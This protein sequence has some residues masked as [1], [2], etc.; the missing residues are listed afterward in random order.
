MEVDRAGVRFAAVPSPPKGA[1]LV[2]V[3]KAA[4]PNPPGAVAFSTTRLLRAAVEVATHLPE[5]VRTRAAA[6]EVR[7]YDDIRLELSGG[8]TVVWGSAEQLT[9]KGKV[10][11]ALLKAVPHAHRY[12]VSS[13]STPATGS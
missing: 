9:Q 5:P 12:D 3:V 13:P 2:K 11:T 4:Q 10:L 7:T 6:V 8:R 1:P